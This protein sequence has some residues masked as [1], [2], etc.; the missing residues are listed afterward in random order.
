MLHQMGFDT[1]IDI[2]KVAAISRDMEA[3]LGH[4]L[5]GQLYKLLGRAE[6]QVV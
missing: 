4:E 2:G 6:V 3:F 1:G 5:P